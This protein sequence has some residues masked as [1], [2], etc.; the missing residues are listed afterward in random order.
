MAVIGLGNT[1][2]RMWIMYTEMYPERIDGIDKDEY[3]ALL[4]NIS[5]T[6]GTRYELYSLLLHKR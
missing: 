6:N 1:V 5:K 3:L 4:E 2:N